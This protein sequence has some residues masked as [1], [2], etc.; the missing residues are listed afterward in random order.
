MPSAALMV[1]GGV[2]INGICIVKDA[3]VVALSFPGVS[4]QEVA[5]TCLEL[6]PHHPLLHDCAMSNDVIGRGGLCDCERLRAIDDWCCA[7]SSAVPP[8]RQRRKGVSDDARALL[9]G[10]AGAG[11]AQVGVESGA[12]SDGVRG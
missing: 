4:R 10:G 2:A 6:L 9:T 7:S 12:H 11:G 3:V 1:F 5:P 8:H